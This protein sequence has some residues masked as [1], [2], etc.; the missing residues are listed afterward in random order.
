VRSALGRGSTF[1][2]RLP[3]PPPLALPQPGAGV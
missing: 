2:V 1:T 3:L